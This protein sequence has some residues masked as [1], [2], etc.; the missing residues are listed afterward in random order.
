MGL[1]NKLKNALFEE[2]EI[3]LEPTPDKI[4]IKDD[5][6][7]NTK[8][9][10]KEAEIKKEIPLEN[11][12]ELFKAENTFNFPDFDEEEFVTNYEPGKQANKPTE[13]V[14]EKKIRR[15]LEFEDKPSKNFESKIKPTREKEP[16]R[17]K[18]IPEKQTNSK[19]SFIPSPAISPVYGI[20]DKSFKKEE[21]LASERK[22][23]IRKTSDVDEI[24][25]KAFGPLGENSPKKTPKREEHYF[26]EESKS[27]DDLLKDSIDETIELNFDEPENREMEKKK[28]SVLNNFSSAIEEELDLDNRNL[29]AVEEAMPRRSKRVDYQEELPKRK[30]VV[31]KANELEDTL[32]NDLYN[33]IDAMYDSRE[34]E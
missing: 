11:E 33:L 13:I 31:E 15:E 19:K 29:E 1:F 25:K 16:M 9:K 26:K 27:I 14:E 23:K 30:E 4:V 17:E 34:E 2:E 21:F 8:K 5:E 20:M 10:E 7:I 12:R 24:R 28:R 6:N 32:E 3:D 18:I 22:Q